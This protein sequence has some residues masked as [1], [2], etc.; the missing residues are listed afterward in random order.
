M[1]NHD[2][3]QGLGKQDCQTVGN[4]NCILQIELSTLYYWGINNWDHETGMQLQ[5]AWIFKQPPSVSWLVEAPSETHVHGQGT[6]AVPK[7]VRHLT[8]AEQLFIF[9]RIRLTDFYRWLTSYSGKSW[10]SFICIVAV[11]P[12]F[13]VPW[14]FIFLCWNMSAGQSVSWCA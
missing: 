12:F 3:C 7:P 10:I 13:L 2:T 11:H 9:T 5:S 14:S 6:N 1:C 4:Q 8:G